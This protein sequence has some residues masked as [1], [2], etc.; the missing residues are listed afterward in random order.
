MPD[1]PA[2]THPAAHQALVHGVAYISAADVKGDVAE[3]GA[4]WGASAGQIA[5]AMAME[6]KSSR[7]LWLFD[8]FEGLP[9]ATNEVDL[10]SP[11]VKD[12]TW[13]W[14][15]EKN[16]G[17]TAEKLFALVSSFLPAD[18]IAIGD[19]WFKDTLHEIPAGTTFAMVHIDCD[20]YAPTAEVLGHLFGND[21]LSDG[22]ALFFDDWYCNRGSYKWGEQKAFSELIT[23]LD[24]R[25]SFTDWGP[26]GPL[27]HKYIVHRDD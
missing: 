19:G 13:T 6:T 18:R 25:Y 22:C 10:Q 24:E 17:P 16:S 26:Y 21:M 8:S 2:L 3:F 11:H 27:G 7:K 14:R 1:I 4:F 12:G 23:T 20:L 9:E 15:Y 5:N